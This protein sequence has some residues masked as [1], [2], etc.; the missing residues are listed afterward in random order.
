M[1]LKENLNVLE[2]QRKVQTFSVPVKK[3]ITKTDIEG[4]ENVKTIFYK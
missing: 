3:E 1:N 2:K 4:N